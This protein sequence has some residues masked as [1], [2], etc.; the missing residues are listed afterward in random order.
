[1]AH[2]RVIVTI[3]G[4]GSNG[5]SIVVEAD[6]ARL[7]IDAGFPA[8]VLAA[9]MA[10]VSIAPESISALV[11]THEH[12]DHAIGARVAARKWG[13]TVYATAGTIVATP[14]LARL[15]P[16]VIDVNQAIAF[17]TMR[18]QCVRTPHDASE[19]IAVVVE[20]QSCGTRVGIAYDLGHVPA[21][22]E[23]AMRD[24]DALVV[25][26]NYDEQMLRD[27]PYPFSV[28]QRISGGRGHLN[29]LAASRLARTV[30]HRG[31]R[32]VVLAHI[33]ENNNTVEAA[34]STVGAAIRGSAF[35]GTL[36]V[37]AQNAVTQFRAER[38]RRVEQLS[39]GL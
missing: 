1:V 13:W 22:I 21:R 32:H 19:S 8:R 9:R 34:R 37:A 4:S 23:S 33:S 7:L 15:R 16:I 30:A 35:R 24:L 25:E 20:G 3:L 26:A 29:N 11:L 28:Q 31:L 10:T 38:A 17:E 5:N 39:L 18:V 14:G 27:G 36:S 12:T 6:G 2:G